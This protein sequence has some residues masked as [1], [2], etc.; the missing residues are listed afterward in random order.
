MVGDRAGIKIWIGMDV[1]RGLVWAVV[2]PK[3]SECVADRLGGVDDLVDGWQGKRLEVGG[4][5][6]RH[7]GAGDLGRR[8]VE[9]V[10]RLDRDL[11]AD[12]G[13]DGADRPGFLDGDDAIGLADGA[14]DR[15]PVDRAQGAQID[16]FGGDTVLGRA[17]R[18]L[19]A[20]SSCRARTRRS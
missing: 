12:L 17:F 4:V 2:V 16:D 11:G 18:R 19:R 13:A 20:R 10:E 8:R 9:I 5:R 7:V 3:G 14:Q 6:H 1:S 15:V